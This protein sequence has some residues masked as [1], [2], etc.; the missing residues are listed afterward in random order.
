MAARSDG[1]LAFPNLIKY[2][3]ATQLRAIASWFTQRSYNRWTEIEKIWLA[4]TH[5]NNLLWNARAGV[6]P[7]RLLGAVSHLSRLWNKISHEHE[8]SSEKSVLT[9]FI[10]NP[11]IPDSLTRQMSHPWSS[12]NLFHYGHIVD[13]RTRRLLPYSDLQTKYGLPRQAFYSYLQIRHY[14]LSIASDLQFSPPTPFENLIMGGTAQKGLISD[15]YKI[16][17]AYPLETKGKHAYMIKWEKALEE[18][19]PMEQW[20]TIWTQ[21]AKSSLCISTVCF[22]PESSRRPVIT[23]TPY[24]DKIFTGENIRITCNVNENFI[25]IHSYYWDFDAKTHKYLWYK[26]GTEIQHTGQTFVI[27]SAATWDSG[28]YQCEVFNILSDPVRL[29]VSH[30]WII[31]QASPYVYEDANVTLRCHHYPGYSARQTIFYKDN[32]VIRDWGSDHLLH[33]A[34]VS[35]ERSGRYKCTKSIFHDLMYYQHSAEMFLSVKELFT[36]PNLSA[37]PDSVLEGEEVTLTCDTNLSLLREESELQFAF[38][39]NGREIQRFNSSRSYEIQSIEL[40][41]SGNYSCEVALGEARKRSQELVFNVNEFFTDPKIKQNKIE[42]N[43]DVIIEGDDMNLICHTK[44]HWPNTLEYA[45][46]KDGRNVKNFSPSNEYAAKPSKAQD[47]GNYACE[48]HMPYLKLR[49]RSKEVYI[50]IQ[51]EQNGACCPRREDRA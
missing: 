19:L 41:D 28:S 20:Q 22:I 37:S 44:F 30:D 42:K 23:F 35:L 46:Y 10:C 38:Y 16:I 13:P 50:H 24:W 5:P 47:S 9:S 15:I 45:F 3:Q 2:Y 32:A 36:S 8:L 1:G 6:P 12:R 39:K 29:D 4:P 21:A 40:E 18:E 17:N 14:A 48:V 25:N 49:K 34:N 11:K 26:D 51:G 33:I 7:E 27:L 31:L 43:L